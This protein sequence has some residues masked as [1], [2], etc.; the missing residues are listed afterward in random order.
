[1]IIDFNKIHL[2]SSSQGKLNE[3]ASFGLN[4]KQKLLPDMPEVLGTDQEVI[5]YKAITF[6]ANILVEDTS[7]D[8]E[9]EAVGINVKYLL[10]ELKTNPKY[11]GKKAVWT[12]WLGLIYDDFLY[13]VK[14]QINGKLSS[15][16]A[17]DIAFGFDA[18]FIPDSSLLTLAQL[19]NINQKHNFSAR[20]SALTN[21][22]I[23]NYTVV[24]QINSIKPW[25]GLYQNTDIVSNKDHNIK[26]NNQIK[27]M[28]HWCENCSAHKMC[29]ECEELYMDMNRY[30]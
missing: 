15:T 13:L 8:V 24:I 3:Y 1:M 20:K 25:T 17:N 18:V 12:V 11:D 28:M 21:M 9:G 27:S 22:I 30:G 19:D 10:S 7:L 29:K 2:G 14:S 26:R 23:G 5:T 4:V 6:G 16:N